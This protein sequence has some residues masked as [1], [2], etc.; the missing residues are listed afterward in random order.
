MALVHKKPL[1]AGAQLVLCTNDSINQRQTRVCWAVEA[2][3]S[4][5]G[6]RVRYSKQVRTGWTLRPFISSWTAEEH[7][8]TT[9]LIFPS[10]DPFVDLDTLHCWMS[11]SISF[12]SKHDEATY[13]EGEEC[14]GAR[15]H[16]W[17]LGN[18]N[19]AGKSHCS[20]R[21]GFWIILIFIL[22]LILNSMSIW[23][24]FPKDRKIL[25]SDSVIAFHLCQDWWSFR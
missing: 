22:I 4:E 16:G 6:Y 8:S 15:M 3:K 13:T 2:D 19:L 17:V 21:V 12:D 24:W 1:T 11:K 10:G 25:I 5:K 14:S 7:Q 23:H 18:F 20:I 9:S